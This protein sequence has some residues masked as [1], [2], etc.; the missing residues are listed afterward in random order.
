MHE[1]HA[2]L[3]DIIVQRVH[4]IQRTVRHGKYAVSALG[5]ERNAALFKKF[6]CIL[7]GKCAERTVQKPRIARHMRQKIIRTA[8]VGDIAPALS[9]DD[10]LASH[11][12]VLFKQG[13]GCAV[14]RR[15]SGRHQSRRAAADDGDAH[16]LNIIRCRVFHTPDIR[17]RYFPVY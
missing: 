2:R 12:G 15:C 16:A 8:I 5:L 6:H 1:I 7:H 11:L 13:D 10:D 4:D 17:P 14:Q 3:A 9:G